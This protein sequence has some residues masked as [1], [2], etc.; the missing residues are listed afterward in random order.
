MTASDERAKLRTLLNYW[1]EHN[2]EHSQEFREWADK[3]KVLGE[4]EAGE[5]MLRA[6]QEM[7]KA[8]E[9]LSQALR[10]IEGK[11]R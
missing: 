2:K 8:S 5:D 7:D 10:R 11:E 6:A 3:A 4:A 1:I 9:I